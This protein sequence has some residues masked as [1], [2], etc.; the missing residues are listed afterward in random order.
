MH[1]RVGNARELLEKGAPFAAQALIEAA[2]G[3]RTSPIQLQ[4]ARD[5]LNWALGKPQQSLSVDA[6]V[7]PFVA[8]MPAVVEDP[9]AWEKR[10]QEV[11]SKHSA[12]PVIDLKAEPSKTEDAEVL[13]Y[14]RH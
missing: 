6:T 9:E 8:I 3:R 13:K 12:A 7:A 2:Q 1:I 4:A 5:V 10:A 11:L 14:G